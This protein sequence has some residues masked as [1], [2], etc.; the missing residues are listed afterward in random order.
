MGFR[1]ICKMRSGTLSLRFSKLNLFWPMERKFHIFSRIELNLA[2]PRLRERLQFM[3]NWLVLEISAMLPQATSVRMHLIQLKTQDL[4]M[5]SKLS[6]KRTQE[7]NL[8]PNQRNQKKAQ[9]KEQNLVRVSSS[10]LIASVARWVS[11]GWTTFREIIQE[12]ALMSQ[13]K[14][15]FLTWSS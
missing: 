5:E 12:I 4:S 3:K 13:W 9:V 10:S 11:R 8:K 14:L 7:H 2:M 1:A 15:T 6:I